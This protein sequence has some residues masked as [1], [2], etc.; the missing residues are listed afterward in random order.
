ER[1]GIETATHHHAAVFTVLL[2]V[3]DSTAP[4]ED[5]DVGAVV[6]AGGDGAVLLAALTADPRPVGD[7]DEV[8]RTLQVHLLN[9]R[10]E[11]VKRKLD[12]LSPQAEDYSR[13]LRDLIELERRRVDP[14]GRD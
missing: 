2:P 4:G 8:R 12:S 7:P 13:L 6:A 3:L 14:G 11:E 5:V 10:I 9:D 1:L